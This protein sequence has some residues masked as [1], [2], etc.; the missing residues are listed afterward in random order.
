MPSLTSGKVRLITSKNAL[1]KIKIIVSFRKYTKK[2]IRNI[3]TEK[4]TSIE[5]NQILKRKK[6]N[7]R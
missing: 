5:I 6:S 2:N 7:F 3:K 4:F 1:L